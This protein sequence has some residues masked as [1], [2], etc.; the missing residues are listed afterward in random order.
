M[1]DFEK[2][3]INKLD[4]QGSENRIIID[5]LFSIL[6]TTRIILILL[7]LWFIIWCVG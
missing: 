7:I 5:M 2:K 1:T 4:R 6:S 3:V